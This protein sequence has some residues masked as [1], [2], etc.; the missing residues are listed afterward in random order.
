MADVVFDAEV[1]FYWLVGWDVPQKVVVGE[2]FFIG[3]EPAGEFG[4][5]GG[6]AGVAIIVAVIRFL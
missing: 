4:F 1:E 2:E 3:R 6:V 5:W